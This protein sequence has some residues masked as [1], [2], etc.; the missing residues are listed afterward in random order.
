MSSPNLYKSYITFQ[1]EEAVVID[2]N[3]VFEK[4]LKEFQNAAK[5]APKEPMKEFVPV[6]KANTLEAANVARL[7]GEEID[8]DEEGFSQGI[9]A[10]PVMEEYTGPAPEELVENA[11]REAEEILQNAQ[12]EAE[13][14]K[15][16]AREEGFSEGQQAGYR[17]AMEL[18][19]S[20][21]SQKEQELSEKE[22]LLERSYQEKI[23]ELEPEFVDTLTGIYEHIFK[24]NL[25]QEKGMI[26]HLLEVNM[27]R[28]GAGRN[29]IIHVSKDDF[30]AV[31][32]KKD[33]IRQFAA[34]SDVTLEVIE[35]MTLAQAECMIETE[36]GIFDCSLGVQLEELSKQLQLLSYERN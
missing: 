3:A 25:K 17:E 16:R 35:D 28:M 11:K 22:E 12:A 26:V 23:K 33:E 27:S 29:F 1:T 6:E 21:I 10:Q 7:L 13:A 20:E 31:S 24:V 9:E 34:G 32:A 2:S 18:A 30:E 14:L 8:M 36:G 4:R 5:E 15:L 19:Q